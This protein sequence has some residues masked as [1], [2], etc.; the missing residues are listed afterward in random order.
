MSF[1][2]LISRIINILDR[3]VTSTIIA[4][5]LLVFLWG[6]I[7]YLA[8]SGNEEKRK[9]SINYIIAGLI[10]LFVM[11]AIWGIVELVTRTLGS[12]LGIPQIG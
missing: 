9:D 2:E 12:P 8:N 1:A 4:L 6:L 7:G 5:A 10:G 11:V 3:Y